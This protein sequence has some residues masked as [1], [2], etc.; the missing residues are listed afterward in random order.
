MPR[1]GGNT[2]NLMAAYN[3]VDPKRQEAQGIEDD[4]DKHFQQTYEG[5]DKLGKP[6]LIKSIS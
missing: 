6:E 3:A 5:G 4:I 1:V 2:H